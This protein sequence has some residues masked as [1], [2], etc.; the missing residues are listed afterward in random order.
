MK[1][2]D[3]FLKK[4]KNGDE[5]VCNCRSCCFS[6]DVFFNIIRFLYNAYSVTV[7][8]D[9]SYAQMKGIR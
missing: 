3:I 9:I 4:D 2:A 7:L 5:T 6:T 1:K 8:S